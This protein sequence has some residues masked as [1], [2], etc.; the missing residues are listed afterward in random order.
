MAVTYLQI[1]PDGVVLAVR[2]TPK[3]ARDVVD[4]PGETAD[5]KS[6]LKVRVRAVPEKGKANKALEALLA[7]WLG[8]PASTVSVIA[9]GT[10][11]LKTVMV[12]GD[13]DNLARIVAEKANPL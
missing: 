6:H 2:L 13:A 12:S 10:A 5:G 4:G 9:G 3:A 11:R 8:V 1:R 7:G